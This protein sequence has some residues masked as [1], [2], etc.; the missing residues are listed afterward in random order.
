MTGEQD[1]DTAPAQDT[2]SEPGNVVAAMA[3]AVERVR[4]MATTVFE[5]DAD[6]FAEGS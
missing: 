4:S 6:L 2:D 5:G 3:S 1:I